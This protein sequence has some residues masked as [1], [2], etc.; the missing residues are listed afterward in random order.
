MFLQKVSEV[1]DAVKLGPQNFEG[2]KYVSRENLT[3]GYWMLLVKAKIFEEIF[4]A[5]NTL[6][7]I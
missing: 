6:D 1:E 4:R 5:H 3:L 7:F 2:V